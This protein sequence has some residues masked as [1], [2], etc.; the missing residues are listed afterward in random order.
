MMD[1]EIP[2]SQTGYEYAPLQGLR[3]IRLLTLHPAALYEAPVHISLHEV[4]LDASANFVALSYTWA[5][6]EGDCSFSK[7]VECDGAIMKITANCDA[8]LRRIRRVEMVFDVWIDAICINQSNYDEKS[9]QIPLMRQIYR[10][11]LWVGLW[12]GEASSTLDEETSR[13]FTDLAMELIHNL[14]IELQGNE[15]SGQNPRSGPLYQEVVRERKA[16]WRHGVGAFSPSVQGLWEIFHRPLWE[17]L[18]VAQEVSLARLAVL[19]CGSQSVMFEMVETVVDGLAREHPGKSGDEQEFCAKFIT[20]I[21]P[22]FSMRDF[23]KRTQLQSDYTFGNVGPGQKAIQILNNTRNLRAT[24]PRDKIYGILGFFG[25][26]Q[27]D[28]ENIFPAPDYSKSAADLYGDI[29]RTIVIKTKTL[30]VLSACYGCVRTIPNLPSWAPSWNHT[31][32]EYFSVTGFKAANN[33][34]IVYEASGD[35]KSLKL[36]GK[37]VDVVKHVPEIPESL[38]Y[39]DLEC[40][41]LWRQWTRFAFSLQSY[42]TGESIA[43]V[44]LHTLCWSNNTAWERLTMDDY[45]NNFEAWLKIL[46]SSNS[47]EEVAK[48]LYKDE[49]ACSYTH[50]AEFLVWGRVLTTTVNSYLALVPISASADD[51]IVILSGGKI[52]FVLRA[53]DDNFKIIGPCYVHGIM[54]GEAFP[55]EEA[56]EDL[57]WFTLR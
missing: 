34:Y 26:P 36:K 21:F 16:F 53:T 42:P 32:P 48:D 35:K 13:P 45:R 4:S 22:H 27:S 2:L 23:V 6:E 15:D 20:S 54:D 19:L 37:R 14:A 10:K 56:G 1:D 41:R 11:A 55:K 46:Q 8:A 49:M 17:R 39:N 28:P 43:H 33:S 52:P 12:I 29:A 9:R 25:D 7:S 38:E 50:R 3:T 18:W 44:L 30:D 47:L 31:L 24:D 5:T 57:E 51:Q 40:T